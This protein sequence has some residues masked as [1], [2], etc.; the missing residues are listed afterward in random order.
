MA[1]PHTSLA[2]ARGR[3]AAHQASFRRSRL[4]TV[5]AAIRAAAAP[6][7]APSCFV[8]CV[9]VDVETVGFV[10]P[11]SHGNL[12]KNFLRVALRGHAA[13]GEHAP[14]TPVVLFAHIADRAT[15]PSTSPRSGFKKMWN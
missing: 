4:Q 10:R 7:Q 12:A 1:A 13:L 14:P 9:F 8:L 6:P 11:Q 5:T 3:P 15:D 2:P